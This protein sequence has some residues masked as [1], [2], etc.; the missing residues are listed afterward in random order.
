M[1]HFSHFHILTHQC[2]IISTISSL[3][4]FS[5][6]SGFWK[7]VLLCFSYHLQTVQQHLLS[8]YYDRQCSEH[9][10]HELDQTVDHSLN[11]FLFNFF[12]IF[13][14]FCV[15]K[16]LIDILDSCDT[17]IN[18][19]GGGRSESDYSGWGRAEHFQDCFQQGLKVQEHYRS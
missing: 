16:P 17:V 2:T 18:Q 4:I 14:N 5:I 19:F 9:S 12:N 10:C 13:F 11:R 15:C 7:E 8:A 3:S 1:I 6:S